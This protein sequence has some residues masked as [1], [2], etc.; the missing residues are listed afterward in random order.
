MTVDTTESLKIGALQHLCLGHRLVPVEDYLKPKVFS[1][2]PSTRVMALSEKNLVASNSRAALCIFRP[3]A[4]QE[5][6]AR[7][8]VVTLSMAA[9]GSAFDASI[10]LWLKYIHRQPTTDPPM[11]V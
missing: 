2:G 9:A 10:S 3:F 6:R 7:C 8:G 1:V 11:T 4:E 5:G